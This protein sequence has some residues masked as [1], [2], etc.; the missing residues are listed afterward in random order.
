MKLLPHHL[1]CVLLALSASGDAAEW[2]PLSGSY[3]VTTENYLDPAESESRNSHFRVQL[4]GQAAKDL[5][6]AMKVTESKDE[7]T[8][9]MAKKVEAMQC[10]HYA[11][12]ERYVCA[13]SL[14]VM[15]QKIEYGVSC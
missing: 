13:F 7:C 6:M 2:K 4:S 10:I 14:N 3:A 9:A 12:P 1:A 15:A 8:G 11:S 5:F